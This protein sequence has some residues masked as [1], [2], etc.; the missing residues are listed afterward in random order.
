MTEPALLVIGKLE[1][2]LPPSGPSAGGARWVYAVDP[3]S[4][5]NQLA[6]IESPPE[7]IVLA[8]SRPGQ[9][10]AE[11]IDAM[12]RLA[13]LARMHR[14]LGTWCEGEQRTGRPPAG[15]TSSYWHQ[16]HPRVERQLARASS[17]LR[18]IWVLPSTASADEQALATADE[19]LA[20][21]SGLVVIC[22]CET[23]AAE[24]LADVCR[25]AGYTTVIVRDDQQWAAPG[26]VAVVWD[27]SVERAKNHECVETICRSAG[28]AP[29][30]ALI[31][32][33]RAEDVSQAT[34]G[35]VA[36][37]V[38]KPFSIHDMLWQLG[39]VVAAVGWGTP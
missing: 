31:G 4:A 15:C 18:P 19:P 39:E 37:V 20:R 22:A 32:F 17:G 36:A 8:E 7:L 29:L 30:V 25:L 12:R 10:S 27:T 34:H 26:A 23:Q 35:R 24:S 14:L 5:A 21:G 13:P 2:R 16:W 38:S 33:P 6:C 9:F 28:G 11:S 1:E 3:L